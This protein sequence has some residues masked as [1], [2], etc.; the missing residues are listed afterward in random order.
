MLNDVLGCF[1]ASF[2]VLACVC[3]CVWM[4]AF[5]ITCV[6]QK[7]NYIL[8]FADVTDHSINRHI[9]L[10]QLFFLLRGMRTKCQSIF[11][12]VRCYCY[13]LKS[14]MWMCVCIC[15]KQLLNCLFYSFHYYHTMTLKSKS[16]YVWVCV[17]VYVCNQVRVVKCM[18]AVMKLEKKNKHV[19]MR[20]KCNKI[21][22][23]FFFFFLS[24]L[25]F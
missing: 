20:Y 12:F 9:I 3:V 10:L 17:G 24:E 4:N 16:V 25:L 21:F 18:C 15:T 13:L 11:C 23:R 2:S 19:C 22:I 6:L 5:W 1:F 8:Y 14:V 7:C